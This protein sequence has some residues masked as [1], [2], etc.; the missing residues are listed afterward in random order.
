MNKEKRVII[1]KGN[2]VRGAGTP[3]VVTTINFEKFK[4]EIFI[5]EV[6]I[7]L[8]GIDNKFIERSITYQLSNDFDEFEEIGTGLIENEPLNRAKQELSLYLS[9]LFEQTKNNHYLQSQYSL[10]KTGEEELLHVWFSGKFKDEI[11][12]ISKTT[13]CNQ[14]K[15]LL[16]SYQRHP[17]LITNKD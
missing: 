15:N 6:F 3:T 13:K 1:Y 16:E 14:L 7:F 17:H 10:E 12:T 5:V 2:E 9:E 11:N 8:M 4:S